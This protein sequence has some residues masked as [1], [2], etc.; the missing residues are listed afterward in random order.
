MCFEHD[1]TIGSVLERLAFHKLLSGPVLIRQDHQAPGSLEQTQAGS[2]PVK[3]ILGFVDLAVILQALLTE[4][5]KSNGKAQTPDG[6][7]ELARELCERP[8]QSLLG[9]APSQRALIGSEACCDWLL[10]G[11]YPS[12]VA[13]SG[14]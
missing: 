13:G 12:Y 14:C 2:I 8:I 5:D 7:E 4:V 6:I 9:D 3:S 1:D 10:K 11:T